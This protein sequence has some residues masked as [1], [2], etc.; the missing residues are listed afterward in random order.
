MAA[1]TDEEIGVAGQQLVNFENHSKKYLCRKKPRNLRSA[2]FDVS[3]LLDSA[4][5]R[6]DGRVHISGF[7]LVIFEPTL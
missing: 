7:P 1:G 5:M 2:A 6:G 4:R 3:Y